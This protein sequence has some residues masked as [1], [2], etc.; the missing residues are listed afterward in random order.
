MGIAINRPNLLEAAL[1][2][3]KCIAGDGTAALPATPLTDPIPPREVVRCQQCQLIQFRTQSDLCRR[4]TKPLPSL[5]Q[6]VEPD[7]TESAP[8][9]SGEADASGIDLS[10]DRASR[11]RQVSIGGKM[12]AI[13]EERI[14][15]Q[16]EMSAVLGIPRS[17]LSRIENSR[18]LPG[19]LMVARFASSLGVGIADLVGGERRKDG[20][21]L[22]PADPLAATLYS[23]FARLQPRQME[24]VLGEA[25]RMVTGSFNPLPAADR[26]PESQPLPAAQSMRKGPARLTQSLTHSMPNSELPPAGTTR[27]AI[28]PAKATSA[29]RQA[30]AAMRANTKPSNRLKLA[31]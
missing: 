6:F 8:D 27:L 19:P 21:R 25:R 10:L 29:T 26:P 18:L 14:L 15:T 23:Q 22:F 9:C 20:G 4:C 12:K 1:P 28:V 11:N 16:V 13:R 2:A 7:E 17:Y 24:T 30:A 3:A 31:R 5:L